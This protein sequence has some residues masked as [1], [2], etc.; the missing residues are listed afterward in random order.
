MQFRAEYGPK[1]FSFIEEEEKKRTHEH[2]EH[3]PLIFHIIPPYVN[4]GT[5]SGFLCPNQ[6]SLSMFSHLA[7]I[8][9]VALSHSKHDSLLSTS[10]RPELLSHRQPAAPQAAVSLGL[11]F[12]YPSFIKPIAVGEFAKC[13]GGDNN[14]LSLYQ[15][16]ILPVDQPADWLVISPLSMGRKVCN[17]GVSVLIRFDWLP[18]VAPTALMCL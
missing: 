9:S 6:S 12:N 4:A 11:A 17:R 2:V 18:P 14:V 5:L 3:M 10:T 15:Q 8:Y 13:R 7:L 1:D 16:H